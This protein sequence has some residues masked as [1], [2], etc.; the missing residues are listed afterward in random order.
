LRDSVPRLA[1]DASIGGRSL[2]DI[3]REVLAMARAGLASRN[4]R[5]THERDETCYLDI[6]DERVRSG[7]VAAQTLL[8][9]F[10][11]AWSGDITKVFVAC[12]L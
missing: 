8:A 11:G 3:A 12:A 5:D 7:R 6:L 4:Q 2:R 1:L 10:E 9:Q